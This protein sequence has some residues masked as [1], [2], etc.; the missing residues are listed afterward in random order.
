MHGEILPDL[1]FANYEASLRLPT[2]QRA[3]VCTW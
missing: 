1:G 3:A 2:S